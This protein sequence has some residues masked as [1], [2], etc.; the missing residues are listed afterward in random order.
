[1]Q[2]TP[3]MLSKKQEK[4][5]KLMVTGCRKCQHGRFFDMAFYMV[6]KG[7]ITRRTT[8]QEVD[9]AG[10][11]RNYEIAFYNRHATKYSHPGPYSPMAAI[12][13]LEAQSDDWTGHNV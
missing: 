8:K 5:L 11:E 1:M 9:A 4:H 6:E 3:L 2:T 12:F 7:M 10:M 13:I